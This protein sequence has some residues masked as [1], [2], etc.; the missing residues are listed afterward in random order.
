MY[1]KG[2]FELVDGIQNH[3]LDLIAYKKKRHC[4]ETIAFSY[5]RSYRCNRLSSL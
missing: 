5:S 2:R 4:L 3:D 1:Q